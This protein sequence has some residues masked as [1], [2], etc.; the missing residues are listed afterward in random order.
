MAKRIFQATG[1][2]LHC[3]VGF[4]FAA[5][6]KHVPG[7]QRID[8]H[9]ENRRSGGTCVSLATASTVSVMQPASRPCRATRWYWRRRTRRSRGCLN[10][11]AHVS[12]VDLRRHVD[13]HDGAGSVLGHC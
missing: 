10:G 1:P 12:G 11:D 2:H 4:D 8:H 7:D 6:A 13:G 5:G 3:N 9:A